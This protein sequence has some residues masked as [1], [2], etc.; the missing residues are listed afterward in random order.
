M[1]GQPVTLRIIG[2]VHG[3][4]D[5]YIEIASGAE[6]SLQVGDL[7][8]DY[9][10]LEGRLDPVAH[11]ALGGN[12]DNYGGPADRRFLGDFGVWEPPSGGSIFFV[13]GAWSIDARHRTPGLDWWLDEQL[14]EPQFEEALR[15]YVTTK[16]RFVVTHTAPDS[17]A[18]MMPAPRM[19]GGQMFH[20]RTEM[21][22][23]RMYRAW[24]PDV[25]V[26]GHWHFDW[27]E[28]VACCGKKTRFICL[29]ELSCVDCGLRP[30][31]HRHQMSRKQ[32]K[33]KERKWR[34]GPIVSNV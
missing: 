1:E 22:L 17:I 10:P 16:P 33:C 29:D 26:F 21:A 14:S 8:F 18:C 9:G 23:D 31:S 3:R 6:M 2:D 7:G 13:R 25:W 19:L 15:L 24:Q 20:P 27:D 32:A 11:R 5:R 12:H 34:V 28:E 30:C 4:F